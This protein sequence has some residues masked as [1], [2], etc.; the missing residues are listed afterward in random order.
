MTRF[1]MA[2]LLTAIAITAVF[3]SGA[4]LSQENSN[5]AIIEIVSI[6]HRDPSWVRT[7]IRPQLD[8]RGHIGQIDN[9]LVIATTVANYQALREMI[10]GMDTPARRLV[11]SVDFAHRQL[12]ND[13]VINSDIRRLPDTSAQQSQQALEGDE[14]EFIAAQPSRAIAENNSVNIL[15]PANPDTADTM[16]DLVLPDTTMVETDPPRV[17]LLAEIRNNAAAVNVR[18]DNVDGFTGRYNLTL[19]LG[20]WYV[21]NPDVDPAIAIRVDALP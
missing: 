20:S 3:H 4:V 15:V 13:D 21:L 8:S 11:V 5:R 9:K 6:E 2:A 14:V 1:F 12:V 19:P 17:S 7:Q 16:S 10:A 18:L